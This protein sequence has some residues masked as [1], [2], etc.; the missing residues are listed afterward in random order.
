ML[1]RGYSPILA[2]VLIVILTTCVT[3]LLLNGWSSKSVAAIIGTTVGMIIAGLVAYIAIDLAHISG[4]STPEVEILIVVA[5]QTGMQLKGL[6]FAG[7]LLSSLG[8][9]ID[10]GIAIASSV[11]EVHVTN[12]NLS[13]RNYLFPGLMSGGI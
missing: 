10:V 12:P 7:I 2:S 9:I 5:D 6:L 8:A 3:L 1:Y 11:Y 13:K 4:Y